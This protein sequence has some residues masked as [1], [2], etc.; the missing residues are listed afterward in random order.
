MNRQYSQILGRF[1]RPDPVSPR[2][3]NPLVIGSIGDPQSLDRYSYTRNDPVNLKDSLG[4]QIGKVFML[5]PGC[6]AVQTIEETYSYWDTYGS[7]C[8]DIGESE[9]GS[10]GDG[11]GSSGGESAQD[12]VF[13]IA[14]RASLLLNKEK[15]RQLLASDITNPNI[16]NPITP[17]MLLE[18]YQ[19]LS[20]HGNLQ[21]APQATFNAV[22]QTT[23]AGDAALTQFGPSFFAD[24]VGGWARNR[25]FHNLTTT[26]AQIMVA[27][28]ELGHSTGAEAA[29]HGES[30]KA[31]KRYNEKIVRDC[32]N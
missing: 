14:Y 25:S 32:I 17:S 27:L 30:K 11:G 26:Q 4:L 12:R 5:R 7:G 19:R 15:C 20:R 8:D 23:G 10:G 13:S 2:T 22:A 16:V 9:G 28:H 29:S 24:N 31:S 21:A 18:F 3:D 1:N 6:W